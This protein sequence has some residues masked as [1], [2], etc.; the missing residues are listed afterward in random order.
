MVDNELLVLVEVGMQR[1]N[2]GQDFQ[3][4]L[5]A[6]DAAELARFEIGK[7]MGKGSGPESEFC[8]LISLWLL[9]TIRIWAISQQSNKTQKGSGKVKVVRKSKLATKEL[10]KPMDTKGTFLRKRIHKELHTEAV[11]EDGCKRS[12]NAKFTDL[13]V[14]AGSQPRQSQ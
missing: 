2:T 1:R 7:G 12:R 5:D 11:V 8:G 14:E 10:A 13:M 9:W 4:Q 6:I 3:E